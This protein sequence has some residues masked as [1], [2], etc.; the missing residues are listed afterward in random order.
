MAEECFLPISLPNKPDML[1]Y[2][3]RLYRTLK[4][5]GNKLIT[6][7]PIQMTHIRRQHHL[8]QQAKNTRPFFLFL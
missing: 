1:I 4:G 6:D 3:L 8:P 2:L 5:E 7:I